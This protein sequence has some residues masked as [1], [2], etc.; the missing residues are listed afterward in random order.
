VSWRATRTVRVSETV[1]SQ[2]GDLGGGADL[3][4]APGFP[5]RGP[6]TAKSLASLVEPMA[7]WIGLQ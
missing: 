5:H 4:I 1:R 3:E 7:P 2:Y 6:T